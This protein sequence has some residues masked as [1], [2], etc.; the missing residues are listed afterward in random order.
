MYPY[1][2]AELKRKC[3]DIRECACMCIY[4]CAWARGLHQLLLSALIFG[5]GS[6]AKPG[7]HQLFLLAHQQDPCIFLSASSVLRW[8]ACPFSMRAHRFKHRL[9]CLYSKSCYQLGHVLV[10]NI[11]WTTLWI[12]RL[13]LKVVRSSFRTKHQRKLSL[14][15]NSWAEN[16]LTRWGTALGRSC[17]GI[18]QPKVVA[19]MNIQNMK[20]SVWRV[21]NK[22]KAY[23]TGVQLNM[24]TVASDP[25][26]ETAISQTS[27]T[28]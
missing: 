17:K 8:Q 13:S 5:T 9:S 23:V 21:Q 14:E 25:L 7:S 6:F 27:L 20:T 3:Y 26:R 19:D 16:W 2:Y 12:T 1:S 11:Q 22:P 10:P 28:L 18:F 24:K 4:V 15:I